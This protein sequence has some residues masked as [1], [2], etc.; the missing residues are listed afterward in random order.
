MTGQKKKK[1]GL[2]YFDEKNTTR[3]CH[4]KVPLD[5]ELA[6]LISCTHTDT[7]TYKPGNAY[8]K[9]GVWRVI[10]LR[11]NHIHLH[12][13]YKEWDYTVT[14]TFQFIFFFSYLNEKFCVC[15][16]L[17]SPMVRL[18]FE[19]IHKFS[20]NCEKWSLDYQEGNFVLFKFIYDRTCCRL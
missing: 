9:T 11:Q 3:K 18:N 5:V 13:I 17:S 19:R 16:W 8:Q 10:K 2:H 7:Q 1:K 12:Y 20:D 4:E 14:F 6:S 15:V